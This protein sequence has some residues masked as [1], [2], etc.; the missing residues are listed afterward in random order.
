[1]NV[2]PPIVAAE[3]ACTCPGCGAAFAPGGRGLGK[4]FCSPPCRKR[5][6]AASQMD[7]AVLAPLVKAWIR[8]RHAKPDTRAAEICRFARQQLTEIAGVQFGRDADAGRDPVTFVGTLMD[9][10]TRYIDRTR[11]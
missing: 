7:G 4:T 11:K 1:M 8:T 2:A 10:G 5:F 9:S 6:H 3:L